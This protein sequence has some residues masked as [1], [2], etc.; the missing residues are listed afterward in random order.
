[1]HK[2]LDQEDDKLR[3]VGKPYAKNA[4]VA[5]SL[6]QASGEETWFWLHFL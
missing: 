5:K 3:A 4:Y 6:L 1:M 2:S